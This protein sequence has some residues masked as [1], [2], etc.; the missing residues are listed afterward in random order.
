MTDIATTQKIALLFPGQGSQKVGMGR[1]LYDT[2][3]AAR[4]IFE[5]A[6]Q[7]LGFALSDLIFNG[8]EDQL[9]LTEHTQPA[10]L[11]VSVAAWRALAPELES[12]GL[13][14]A[15]AAGH[16]LGEYSAHVA[17][18]TLS[19]ADAIRTVRLRGQYMQQAVPAGEGAMAAILGLDAECI[20][21]ICAKVSDELTQTPPQNPSDPADQSAAALDALSDPT[22]PASTPTEAASRINA[23]VTPANLNSP[24]QTVISGSAQA[25]ELAAARCK[26]AGARKTVMLAVSAPFHCA[27][28]RPAQ[29]RLSIQLESVPFH[30]P[31]FPVAAN[32]DA[33]LLTRYTEVRDA[34]IRQVTG[35]IRWVGCVRLLQSSGTTH[36]IEVGPGKVLTGL[37]RQIDRALLTT[38]VEDQASLEKTLAAF[39]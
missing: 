33:R 27:L 2:Y 12:R 31:A 4:A 21:D 25:V 7:A 29:D 1:N 14:P 8:P 16:S 39:V 28:M 30:D 32:V 10:I 5:E 22:N 24:D 15:F 34:L 3:P 36:Y 38:H 37:N 18:G 9:K 23:V 26:E 17:A 20:N 13:A 6:D 19:F 11:T 35:A